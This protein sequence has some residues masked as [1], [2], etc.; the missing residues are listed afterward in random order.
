[1]AIWLNPDEIALTA[2]ELNDIG[3]RLC[4]SIETGKYPRFTTHDTIFL[5]HSV[6]CTEIVTLRCIKVC[7]IMCGSNLHDTSSELHIHHG[8]RDNRD[9]F[10]DNGEDDRASDELFV[11]LVLGVDGNCLISEECLRSRC[12]NEEL[13]VRSRDKVVDIVHLLI[14]LLILHLDI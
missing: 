3:S 10:V 14:D 11:A 2:E 1:M 12:R 9:F 6:V 5:Y 7:R 13:L 4:H 8:I